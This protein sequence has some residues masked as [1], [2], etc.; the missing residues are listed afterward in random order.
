MSEDEAERHRAKMARRKAVQ[1]A[2]VAAKTIEKGLLMVH[3][4][5]GKGKS[6]AAFGLALR[7]LGQ[8][9]GVGVVQ[10]I[11]GAWS[12]GE[13]G[14]LERL[15]GLEWHS[16]GEGFTW[17]TQ[18]RARDIA[19]CRR[20]WERALELMQRPGLGLLV[21]DELCIALRYGYLPV[22]EVLA[23]LAGRPAMLH[24]VVTGRNAPP[25]LVEAADLVTEMLPV[26]HHFAAGVKAQAGI[27]F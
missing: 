8:G 13:R 9:R 14:V 20:A 26:K 24:A 18:D 10:F 6:T 5:A 1:D 2:E 16:M 15:P 12:T 7:M 19:A 21:L 25:A 4:G 22:E 17:E 3:T 11:K 27:E 23:G